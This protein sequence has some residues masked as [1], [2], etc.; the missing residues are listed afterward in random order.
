MGCSNCK[1]L[2]E[3]DKKEGKQLGCLYYCSKM[4]KYVNGNDCCS[5]YSE[6]YGRNTYKRDKIYRDGIKYSNDTTEISTY[7]FI[8]IVLFILGLIFNVFTI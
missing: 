6:D 4:K 2:K 1:I 5:E 7:I 3:N 8:L